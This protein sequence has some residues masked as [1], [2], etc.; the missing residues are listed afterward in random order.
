MCGLF[1]EDGRH[2]F[3]KCKQVKKCWQ[4]LNLEDVR[5]QLLSLQSARRVVEVIL[6]LKS[7][8]RSLVI[9]LLWAWWGNRNK[10]N[11][12]EKGVSV[13]EVN[14][15]VVTFA[16]CSYQLEKRAVQ[17]GNK[18]GR[19]KE[20][21]VPPPPDVLK[22]NIDGAFREVGKT[23]AWGFVI[24]DCD[25][26]GV[27]EG[28]G[29]LKW[30]HDALMAEG[31]ACLA[32]LTVAMDAGISHVVIEADSSNLVAAVNSDGFD[33]A[34]GGVLF[35]EIRLILSLH[36]VTLSF[37]HVSTSCNNCAHELACAGIHRDPD[38]PVLVDRDRACSES[39]E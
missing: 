25:G 12:G 20:I 3:L 31:E 7:E 1:D 14:R 17:G 5:L 29:R 24:R 30:V 15:R 35:K 26:N 22:I 33:Q 18:G 37:T 21:W 38:Q 16:N 2:C 19:A 32:A 11:P 34:V 28:S 6:K 27:L 13:E 10:A 9:C 8:K 23:G 4:G 36:F 39:N